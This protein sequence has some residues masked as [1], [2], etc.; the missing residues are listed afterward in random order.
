M[1]VEVEM[2]VEVH[3]VIMKL[4]QRKVELPTIGRKHLV[5]MLPSLPVR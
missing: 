2:E 5:E 1:E 3:S 4:F